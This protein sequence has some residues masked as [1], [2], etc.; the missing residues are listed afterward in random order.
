MEDAKATAKIADPD[1]KDDGEA[2]VTQSNVTSRAICTDK[3]DDTTPSESRQVEMSTTK[4]ERTSPFPTQSATNVVPCGAANSHAPQ[5][6]G[7]A[8]QNES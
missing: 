3:S 8:E 1:E 5:D 2:C 6:A 7:V 4:E